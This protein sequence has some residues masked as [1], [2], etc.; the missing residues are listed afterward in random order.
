MKD[1]FLPLLL[2]SLIICTLQVFCL[3]CAW[4]F[5]LVDLVPN[6]KQMDFWQACFLTLLLRA[7][8]HQNT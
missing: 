5:I 6:V 7:V 2:A 1:N 8:I 4:N 3:A